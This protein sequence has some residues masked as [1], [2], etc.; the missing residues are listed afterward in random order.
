MVIE[1]GDEINAWGIYAGGQSGNPG[2]P[3][4]NTFVDDWAAGNYF[5]IN[6]WASYDDSR[7]GTTNI[8]LINTQEEDN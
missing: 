6:F 4:Y 8:K 3:A 2:S 5:K 1:L 7:H